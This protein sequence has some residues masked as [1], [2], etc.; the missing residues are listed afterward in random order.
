MFFSKT[1]HNKPPNQ[2][3]YIF[4]YNIC[5]NIYIFY[6]IILLQIS[7]GENKNDKKI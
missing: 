2:I 7:K 3:C 5:K 1:F 6:Y 4:L